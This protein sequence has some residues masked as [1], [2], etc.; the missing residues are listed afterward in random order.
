MP[1]R[2]I[3]ANPTVAGLCAEIRQQQD[4][5]TTVR[6]AAQERTAGA[7]IPLSSSQQR[8]WFIDQLEGSSAQYH[9]PEALRLRGNLDVT[10]LRFALNEMVERHESLRTCFTQIDGEPR[11]HIARLNNDKTFIT[12]Q[13]ITFAPVV[14][15][16]DK[17]QFTVATQ[18]GFSYTLESSTNLGGSWTA[19]QSVVAQGASTTFEVPA[20]QQYQFFRIRRD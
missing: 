13:D 18:V 3:F 7:E 11:A 9:I 5:G 20:S 1:L 14:R 12:P 17:L 2:T 15:A 19:E 10:A 8:L 6:P 16:G 4:A